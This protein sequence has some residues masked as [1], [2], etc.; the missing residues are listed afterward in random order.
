MK[1]LLGMAIWTTAMIYLMRVIGFENHP[2]DLLWS[3]GAAAMLLFILMVNVVIYIKAAAN[4]P[5][6]WMK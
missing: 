4:D 2:G 1:Q 6:E 5:W 3:L